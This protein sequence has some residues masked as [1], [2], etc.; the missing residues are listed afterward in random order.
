MATPTGRLAFY[1]DIF[2]DSEH[3]PAYWIPPADL[4][5]DAILLG[6]D[7]HYRP[8]HLAAMLRDIRATQRET[9]QLIVVPGNGEYARQELG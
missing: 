8:G 7:I 4:N 2:Y 3:S 6:G 5:V 9:T 1:A